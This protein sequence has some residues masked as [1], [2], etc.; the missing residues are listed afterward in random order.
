[1]PEIKLS[2]R[3]QRVVDYINQNGS[4]TS[5]QAYNDLGITRLS[6]AIY[7]LKH[8]GYKIDKKYITVRNRFNEKCCVAQYRFIKES[9][10]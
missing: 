10:Q 4:I 2:P 5:F 3:E 8:Y 6:A 7:D 9:E 1:M